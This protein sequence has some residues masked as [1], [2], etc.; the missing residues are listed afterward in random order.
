VDYATSGTTE[1][2]I[3][4]YLKDFKKSDFMQSLEIK[5]KASKIGVE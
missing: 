4:I 3:K 1:T 5:L 2:Q